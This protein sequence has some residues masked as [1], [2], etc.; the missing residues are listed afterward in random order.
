[1]NPVTWTVLGSQTWYLL[2]GGADGHGELVNL[3]RVGLQ[4]LPGA[5]VG[6]GAE[7]EGAGAREGLGGTPPVESTAARTS[8]LKPVAWKPSRSSRNERAGVFA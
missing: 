4:V 7:P 8:G 3:L 5:D 2:L 6:G 1:M